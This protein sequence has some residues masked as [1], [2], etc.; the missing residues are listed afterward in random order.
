MTFGLALFSWWFVERPFRA[1]PRTVLR[2]QRGVFIASGLAMAVMAAV[3]LGLVMGKGLPGRTAPSGQSFAA[4]NIDGRLSG[5]RG[6]GPDCAKGF[7]RPETCRSSGPD[8]V[9]LWGDSFA[10]HLALGLANSPDAKGANGQQ[11]GEQGIVQY[12][13][14][15][16][17]PI[18]DISLVNAKYPQ[19]WAK[20]CVAFNDKVLDWLRATPGIRYVVMSSPMGIL[21]E[22]VY[23]RDAGV[24]TRGVEALVQGQMRKTAQAIRA[25]G[26]VPV[27][28]SPPPR[29]GENLA[30]CGVAA[31]VFGRAG[32]SG[33]AGQEDCAFAESDIWQ[34]G[35][36][37][38]AFL[39]RLEPD[40][41]ILSLKEMLCSDGRCPT[42]WEGTLLFRD[43]GHLSDEGS[44]LLGT[45]FDL[46]A[47]VRGLEPAAP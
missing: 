6:L 12:T 46:L 28:V 29:T 16:C 2:S 1:G 31:L 23:L 35:R 32:A 3:G 36:D 45:R 7:E 34:E 9:L 21:R 27:F 13:M 4:L 43:K 22:G 47:K 18:L 19:A 11:G 17:A 39:A 37:I 40:M 26:A 10:M 5:G 15:V 25:A 38:D 44:A 20:G 24:T 42:V 41:R 30:S 14:P 33:R 8:R